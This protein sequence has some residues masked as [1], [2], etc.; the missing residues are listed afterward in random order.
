MKAKSAEQI[1]AV[2]APHVHFLAIDR[3]RDGKGISKSRVMTGEAFAKMISESKS[4]DYIEKMI[5]PEARISGDLAVVSGRYTFY[6]GDKFSHCGTD[7]FNPG[8]LVTVRL[9][10]VLEMPP[11]SEK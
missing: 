6:V 7:T 2:F 11:P 5:S 8:Q 4:P 10:V 9:D 1:K 3:P